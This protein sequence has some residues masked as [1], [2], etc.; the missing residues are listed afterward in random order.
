[1][2]ERLVVTPVLRYSKEPDSATLRFGSSEYLRT[3]V[4]SPNDKIYELEE[5]L[6]DY[7]SAGI[8][9]VWEM[10][11]KFRYVQ[12]HRLDGSRQRLEETETV[13]GEAVL[14]GFSALVSALF[15]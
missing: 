12:I 3:G 15:P 13:T 1:M 4:G 8:K 9:L 2:A 10:N 5:K 11:P 6:A 7:R 14:P